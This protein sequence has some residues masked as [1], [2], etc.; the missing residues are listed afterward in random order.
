MSTPALAIRDALFQRLDGWP[1]YTE[2]KRSPHVTVQPDKL[3]S[4][5]VYLMGETMRADG[6]ANAAEP[7]FISDV[8]IAI[9][10]LRKS[11]DATVIEGELDADADAIEASLLSDMTFV[12]FGGAYAEP[13]GETWVVDDPIFWD[14]TARRA[15]NAPDGN[16]LMGT[17][18][19]P[20]RG[21]AYWKVA[22]LF[23]AVSQVTRRHFFPQQGETYFVELRLEMTFQ[24]RV[25]FDPVVPDWYLKMRLKTQQLSAD[26]DSPQ[27]NTVIDVAHD[28]DGVPLG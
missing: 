10:V 22:G 6:D 9:S 15:T 4:L 23:E 5:A 7:K 25:N 21:I 28:E 11:G 20:E 17:V 3:P 12:H 2:F 27:I 19:R 18:L 13:V 1:G 16:V 24:V 8:V 14:R 26:P